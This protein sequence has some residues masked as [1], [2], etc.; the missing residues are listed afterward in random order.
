M[1]RPT[2][3]A[4]HAQVAESGVSIMSNSEFDQY[5]ALLGGLLRL[6]AAQREEIA[7][8][9]RDHLEERLAELLDQ[10]ISRH[11]AIAIALEEFGDAAGLASEFVQIFQRERRRRIM[12]RTFG[13]VAVISAIVLLASALWPEGRPGPSPNHLVAQER[14]ER[15]SGSTVAAFTNVGRCEFA[16]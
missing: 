12:R 14:S 5:L 8:E 2:V 11:R 15:R 7:S 10:G 4:S 9:L 16:S 1:H 3:V 6:N 13:T